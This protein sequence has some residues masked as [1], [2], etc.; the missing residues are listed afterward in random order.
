MNKQFKQLRLKN[1]ELCNLS[2]KT[3]GEV[4]AYFVWGLDEE[5]IC[6]DH[7][8]NVKI[9]GSAGKRKHKKI[10]KIVESQSH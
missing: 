6:A 5:S 7:N 1:T 8:G 2:N 10:S 3:F 9:I 4:M